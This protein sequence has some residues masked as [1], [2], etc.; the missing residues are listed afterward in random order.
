MRTLDPPA[1]VRTILS[2][3]FDGTLHHPAD[4]PTVPGEFFEEIRRLRE[5]HGAVWGINTGRSM[6][7]MVE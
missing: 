5:H 3:D 7:H 4:D 1:A 2:F 6:P